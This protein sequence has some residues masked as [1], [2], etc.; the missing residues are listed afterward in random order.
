[1]VFHRVIVKIIIFDKY[2]IFKAV[3]D[4][5]SNLNKCKLVLPSR[6]LFLKQE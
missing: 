5:Q 1:M 3:P 6:V 4:T 2:E